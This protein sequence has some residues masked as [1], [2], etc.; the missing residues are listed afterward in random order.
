[1]NALVIFTET[2]A[3][4]RT[5]YVNTQMPLALTSVLPT[6]SPFIDKVG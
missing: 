4:R 5:A 2:I 6:T 3:V 1:M